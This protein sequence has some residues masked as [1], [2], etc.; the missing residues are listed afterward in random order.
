[1]KSVHDIFAV[2]GKFQIWAIPPSTNSSMPVMKL[3]SSE[4]RKRTAEASSSGEP[5]LPN[6]MEAAI[7]ALNCASCSFDG[8]RLRR[9]GVSMGP[10]YASKL[11]DQIKLM[12]ELATKLSERDY[13][14]AELLE[15]AGGR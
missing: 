2:G 7:S 6:G 15:Q 1:M 5:I 8:A 13:L 14:G 12:E 11:A 10:G 9:P 3:L 4:A